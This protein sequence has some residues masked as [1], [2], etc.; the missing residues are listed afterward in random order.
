MNNRN[1]HDIGLNFQENSEG[2]VVHKSQTISD[3]Y[4]QTLKDAREESKG[5]PAGEYHLAASVPVIV[6]ERWLAEGYD[7]T[8]E[9]IKKTL[10]K[11]KAESLDY[12]ITTDKAL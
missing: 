2:L 5:K 3:A 11:L 1:I 4:L 9:P 7:C 10:A 12:F 8:K 6:H